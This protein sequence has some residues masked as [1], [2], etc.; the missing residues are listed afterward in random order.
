MSRRFGLFAEMFASH[1]VVE[2]DFSL[3]PNP[4]LRQSCLQMWLPARLG[5]LVWGGHHK[6]GQEVVA[7]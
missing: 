4:D 1:T 6:R 7:S 2:P 5:Y 3:S